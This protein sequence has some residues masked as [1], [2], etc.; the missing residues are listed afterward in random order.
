[1]KE[2]KVKELSIY[3]FL[4]QLAIHRVHSFA[5]PYQVLYPCVSWRGGFPSSHLFF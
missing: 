1:M 5:K 2:W 4:P 3:L